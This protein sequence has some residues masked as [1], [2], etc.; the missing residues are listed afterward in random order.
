MRCSILH[1]ANPP[2]LGVRWACPEGGAGTGCASSPEWGGRTSRARTAPAAS[3]L[4]TRVTTVLRRGHRVAACC[5]RPGQGDEEVTVITG[6]HA[7]RPGHRGPTVLQN[8]L[9]KSKAGP[10]DV[11]GSDQVPGAEDRAD[12]VLDG[13]EEDSCAAGLDAPRAGLVITSFEVPHLNMHVAPVWYMSDFDVSK[14][15]PE[16]DQS[17]SDEARGEA[18]CRVAR[19]RSRA[20]SGHQPPFVNSARDARHRPH[21]RP[22]ESRA[23][24]T[25]SDRLNAGAVRDSGLRGSA[26]NAHYSQLVNRSSTYIFA[27]RVVGF[28]RSL[29]LEEMCCFLVPGG[30]QPRWPR[31]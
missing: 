14:L 23:R 6:G 4:R 18:P 30:P 11:V 20:G 17:A 21:R 24:V 27:P 7:S 3:V 13:L 9:L 25:P 16:E 22:C 26:P 10:S 28:S 1:R 2:G 31:P 5:G 19:A 8:R 29:T 15:E 12:L